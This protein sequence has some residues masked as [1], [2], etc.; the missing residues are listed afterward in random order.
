MITVIRRKVV[1]NGINIGSNVEDLSFGSGDG[2]VYRDPNYVTFE[3]V[4]Y[5]E[6]KVSRHFLLKHDRG[7]WKM[8]VGIGRLVKQMGKKPPDDIKVELDSVYFCSFGLD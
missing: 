1:I 8:N 6:V 4:H 3:Y 5:D 2:V 7:F